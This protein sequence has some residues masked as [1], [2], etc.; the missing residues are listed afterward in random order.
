MRESDIPS[1]FRAAALK[2]KM[3]FELMR[4]ARSDG[5]VMSRHE[6]QGYTSA[7]SSLVLVRCVTLEPS[8]LIWNARIF[9]KL[10]I[11]ALRKLGSA[12]CMS[13]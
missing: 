7:G 9:Q 8:P 5:G 11:A 13:P 10:D 3:E 2:N 4:L 12:H 6:L 1:I